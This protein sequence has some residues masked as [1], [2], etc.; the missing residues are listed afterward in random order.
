MTKK[1]GNRERKKVGPMH[2]S[3]LFALNL[4]TVHDLGSYGSDNENCLPPSVSSVHTQPCR[5]RTASYSNDWN[6]NNERK[7]NKW[8]QQKSE[9]YNRDL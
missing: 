6:Q 3:P 9:K 4:L 2:G 1:K 5:Q 7:M 8:I